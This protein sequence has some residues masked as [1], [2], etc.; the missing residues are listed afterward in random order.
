MYYAQDQRVKNT[1]TSYPARIIP[2]T[3]PLLLPHHLIRSSDTHTRPPNPRTPPN[4]ATMSPHPLPQAPSRSSDPPKANE[5]TMSAAI[6]GTAPQSSG[7]TPEVLKQKLLETLG[8]TT[9][10]EI[11]DLSG[12]LD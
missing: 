3:P 10:I 12:M 4:H 7:V 2:E 9:E 6:N 1:H 11:E 8:P 5:Y